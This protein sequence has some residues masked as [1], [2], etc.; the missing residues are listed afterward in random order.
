MTA[1]RRHPSLLAA[2]AGVV[3]AAVGFAVAELVAAFVAPGASPLF[4]AGA[5]VVDVVPAPLK[6][7]AIA[8]FGTADKVVLLG[9]MGVVLAAG[10]ALAGWL[11]LRRPPTGAV[12]LGAVGAVGAVVAATRPGSSPAWALP[13]LVGVAAAV[14]LLRAEVGTLRGPAEVAR[15]DGAARADDPASGAGPWT[16]AGSG[17]PGLDRRRFL[18]V[19]GL[20]AAAGVVAL[21][22]SRAVSAGSR[23]V[24]AAREALRL[25]AP[26]VT[27]P[28][29]PAGAD[30]GVPGLAPYV[31]PNDDFYRIDTALRVPQ[32]D[33]DTWTLRVSGLVDEPFE[34]TLAELLALP[35]VEHHLTLTCVSNSVGGDLVGNA[36]W[37]GYPVRELLARAGVQDGADMVLS[38][39]ADGWTASTPLEVLQDEER[40]CLLAVGMNGEPLPAEHGFPARLVVPGLYG[41]V[42]ATKW[43]TELEVTT[44]ADDVAYWSTRGWSER[45]PIKLASRIDTPRASTSVDAGEVTVAGVAWAQHTGIEAVEV[46]V[47]DGPWET[48]TLAETVGPDTW[49]QWSYAWDADAGDHRLTVRATDADGQVQ[50][51]DV[52]AP[53]PDG[54]SGWHE[55]D[56]RVG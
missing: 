22:T 18:L 29:V 33:P 23:A 43:V 55:V 42:S 54:A 51:S 27:A 53:A 30:L 7:W 12:L 28:A 37:L 15:P 26:S 32:V 21:A 3:A 6:E 11:E 39:S 41:Y 13:T 24:T 5:G 48:A 56:V 45:G 47:D 35:L 9:T 1:S 34:L 44:F 52:A 16:A 8:T 10:A 36:L 40:A 38:T 46:R 25:P 31:T 14:L 50:T 49:R 2:L 20:A 4:A 19:T 17:R